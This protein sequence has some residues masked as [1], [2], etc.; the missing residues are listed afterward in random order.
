MGV[1]ASQNI[2]HLHNSNKAHHHHTKEYIFLKG[3]VIPLMPNM[4]QYIYGLQQFHNHP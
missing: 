3:F 2:K 4:R 1:T